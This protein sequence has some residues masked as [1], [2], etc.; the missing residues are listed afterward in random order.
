MS[1]PPGRSTLATSPSTASGCCM[2]CRPATHST[3]STL[4][5]P[6]AHPVGCAFRFLR[7]VADRWGE[8]GT[9]QVGACSRLRDHAAAP[10]RAHDPGGAHKAAHTALPMLASVSAQLPVPP[11]HPTAALRHLTK[12]SVSRGLR[13]SSAALSPWPV[14]RPYRLSAGRWLT[15][16]LRGRG[17]GRS[18]GASPRGAHTPAPLA[19]TAPPTNGH[20]R[21]RLSAAA[22]PTHPGGA[23]PRPRAAA[24]PAQVE[25]VGPLGDAL[26]VQLRQLRPEASIQVVHVARRRVEDAVVAHIDLGPL[27]RIQ[28]LPHRRRCRRI[29]ADAAARVCCCKRGQVRTA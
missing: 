28:H 12:K 3:A 23:G 2:Y 16:E 1:T 10:R 9:G 24:P 8:E 6:S 22:G 25:D 27:A 4:P 29:T 18:G 5:S 19:W 14:T 7:R 11:L 17:R 26:P 13:P 15:Q 20:T 21:N